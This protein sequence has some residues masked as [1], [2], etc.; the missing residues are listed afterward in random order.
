LASSGPI[1]DLHSRASDFHV[2]QGDVVLPTC[3]EGDGSGSF[4]LGE[5][6]LRRIENENLVIF[7]LNYII[8]VIISLSQLP[9]YLS[10]LSFSSYPSI[11][12]QLVVDPEARA[13]ISIGIKSV[14]T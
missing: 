10:F 4:E 14:Y 1:K 9:F 13:I 7:S 3:Y 6:A 5:L 8:I 12:N 2:L 11:N